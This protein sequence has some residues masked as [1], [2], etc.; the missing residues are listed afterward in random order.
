[1]PDHLHVLA[2]GSDPRSDLLEFVRLFK[3]R[4][5][6]EFRKS[7]RKSLWEMGFYDYILRPSDH[8]ED[9][10][11]YIW[12]NPVRK[13]LCEEP[14]EFSF[15]GSQTIDW[16]MRPRLGTA[17]SAPWKKESTARESRKK[18]PTEKERV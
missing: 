9:V 16:I 18:E 13:G 12:W 14:K 3:Q 5:A 2:E 7:T 1:M 8:V 4:T 10:A 17:W 6:F 11:A 15:S